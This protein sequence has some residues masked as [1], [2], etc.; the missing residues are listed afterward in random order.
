MKTSIQG[1]R[2][3]ITMSESEAYR[4]RFVLNY[5]LK[6]QPMSMNGLEGKLDGS[7]IVVEVRDVL[8]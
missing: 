3:I 2:T 1:K 7:E 8:K 6:G 4:V 5:A